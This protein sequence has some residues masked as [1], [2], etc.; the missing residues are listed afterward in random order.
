MNDAFCPHCGAAR[1]PGARFCVECGADLAAFSSS[2]APRSAEAVPSG[3]PDRPAEQL[4]AA[5]VPGADAAPRAPARRVQ[6]SAVVAGAILVVVAGGGALLLSGL[7]ASPSG[8][9]LVSSSSPRSA[10]AQT[11]SSSPTIP[12]VS[13]PA[14]IVVVA[15]APPAETPALAASTPS[16]P[17]VASDPWVVIGKPFYE[18]LLDGN[19]G[20]ACALLPAVDQAEGSCGALQRAVA[21]LSECRG[22]KVQYQSQ[23]FTLFNGTQLPQLQA[24][25]TPACGTSFFASVAGSGDTAPSG[26]IHVCTLNF[27][28][29]NG[30]WKPTLQYNL[31]CT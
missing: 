20:A 12:A 18:A 16:V 2:N 14:E 9:P 22:R 21:G 28:Q 4:Q 6:L 19:A 17:V 30:E 5:E 3:L 10:I 13:S 7:R 15:S 29:V 31:M 27:A 26:P 1:A 8:Q 25:F 23:M 11:P 24:V